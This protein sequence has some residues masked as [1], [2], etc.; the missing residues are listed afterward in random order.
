M[1]LQVRL[2]VLAWCPLPHSSRQSLAPALAALAAEAAALGVDD[3]RLAP[4]SL[5]AQLRRRG[6]G[7]ARCAIDGAALLLPG[8]R[9]QLAHGLEAGL[10]AEAAWQ[11]GPG[12]ELLSWWLSGWGAAAVFVGQAR[13]G[14]P[15]FTHC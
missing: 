13:D 14:C 7:S 8:G 3:C 2:L 9:V 11:Q 10:S 4:A 5:T 6:V 15:R 1:P 12:P